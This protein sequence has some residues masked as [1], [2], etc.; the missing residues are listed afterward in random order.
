MIDNPDGGVFGL[1]RR[2]FLLGSA[3]LPLIAQNRKGAPPPNIVLILADDLAS[4][5]LGCYG[6]T[7]IRTPNI[8]ELAKGG[9]RFINCFTC[10]PTD[11]ACRATMFTGRTPMQHGLQD[12]LTSR[13]VEDPP[14]G[15]FAPPPGFSSE[16]MLSDVLAG[17]G[18]HCGYVGR[19][20]M[21]S[22]QT[23]QHN[24]EYWYTMLPGSEAASY[25]DPRMSLNGQIVNEI[26]LSA[27][28][29]YPARYSLP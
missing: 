6:A 14:Q 17:H 1:N 24:F 8:D 16:V 2:E 20:D 10:A 11:S 28:P 9:M 27:R 13:P 18:Y 22:D 23:P 21:G 25:Q 29:Y 7:E 12:F 3:A 5:M 15:Q 4:Y 26:R 19:W